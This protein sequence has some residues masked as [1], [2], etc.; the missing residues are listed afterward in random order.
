[1]GASLSFSAAAMTAATPPSGASRISC[2]TS[3]TRP[4]GVLPRDGLNPPV[5][6]LFGPR[7]IAGL[8]MATV[9]KL[10]RAPLGRVPST[11]VKRS[12]GLLVALS[13]RTVSRPF[14]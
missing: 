9:A 4:P 14:L 6:I 10:Q 1:M 5:L 7:L 3:Y 11:D 12:G 13:V 2:A 8:P